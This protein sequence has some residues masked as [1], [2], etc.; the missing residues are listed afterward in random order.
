MTLN[1]ACEKADNE[2][3]SENNKQL[4]RSAIASRRMTSDSSAL[5][6]ILELHFRTLL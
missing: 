2:I 4:R 6:A 3:V 1:L 5:I